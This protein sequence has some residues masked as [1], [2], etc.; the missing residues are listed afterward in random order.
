M[1]VMATLF[2]AMCVPALACAEDASPAKP[3]ARAEYDAWRSGRLER[4]QRPE[5]WLSLVG[6]HWLE[7]GDHSIGR[8]KD[9]DIVLAVGPERL[10]RIALAGDVVTLTLAEGVDATI[11]AGT[12]RTAELAADATGAPTVVRFGTANFT[13]IARN[14]RYALRVKDAEAPTRRGFVGIDYYDYDPAW[15]VEGRYEAHAPGSTIEITNVLGYLE[16]MANPG[17]VSF[18]RNGK[19][20]RLEAVDEGDGQLFLIYS[21][22]TNGKDTYGAGRFLYAAPPVA[23]SDRVSIDFNRSYNPPCVFTPYATCPLPPP[24][25][26]LDLAVTVGERKYRGM[27]H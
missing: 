23:G 14:D 12:A 4:L 18:E 25:N 21:D 26:R 20:H 7:A 19:T 8:A 9:N 11:G 1:K 17:V 15:R 10:G 22:R 24:E 27:T 6:L 5:G 2:A 13:V 16:P 3:D